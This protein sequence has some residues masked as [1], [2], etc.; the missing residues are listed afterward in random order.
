VAR[1]A[2]TELLTPRD[3]KER[4]DSTSPKALGAYAFLFGV[5]GLAMGAVLIVRPPEIAPIGESQNFARFL[6]IWT[7]LTTPL[8]FTFAAPLVLL[9]A[10]LYFRRRWA[11]AGLR[12]YVIVL[13]LTLPFALCAFGLGM[14]AFFRELWIPRAVKGS[15]GAF[16]AYGVPALFALFGL[17]VA[18]AMFQGLNL[19]LGRFGAE[20]VACWTEPD[21]ERA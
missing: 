13:L 3:F 5:A 10:G 4:L 2:L 15:F 20:D 9:G 7:A 6:K 11:R 14:F 12:L 1:L 21:S 17:V 16:F 18:S 8:Q 19:L